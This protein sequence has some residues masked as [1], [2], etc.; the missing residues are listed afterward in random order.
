MWNT[1]PNLVH[2]QLSQVKSETM[3]RLSES[4]QHGGQHG[5]QCGFKDAIDNV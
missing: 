5:G 1:V 3:T 2:V 4:S